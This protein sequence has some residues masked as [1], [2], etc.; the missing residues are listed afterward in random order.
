[1][2]KSSK[3]KLRFDTEK[4]ARSSRFRRFAVA[5]SC[6]FII[7]ASI[8]FLLLL[9]HY[10][11]DLSAIASHGDE[12]QTEEET[13]QAPAP[14]VE[15][16]RN[17]LLLCTADSDNS[18]RFIS[19]ATADLNQKILN[20]HPLDP[21]V[22]VDI[23]G[24]N[25]NFR[26]QLDYGGTAQLV[27]AVEKYSGIKID[28]YVRSTDSKFKSII[29]YVGGI[30]INV[31]KQIDIRTPELTAVIAKGPQ[32]MTG[33]IMLKYIRCFEKD[34]IKQA[35]IIA[36]MIEQK[37]TSTNLSKADSYYKKIINLTESDIS[38]VDFADMKRSFRALLYDT[39][40]VSVSVNREG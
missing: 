12:Q 14:E 1:M 21:T 34:H 6:F 24:C 18:I 37:L 22:S 20:I 13:T 36:D 32:T 10:D 17:Y 25:G 8:S 16:I 40:S 19:I 39:N 23:T 7:L 9:S 28:K 27:L 5:F 38:V 15:G 26:E 2:K 4:N 33:D 30:E 3:H 35:E 29:N 31:E 11:F